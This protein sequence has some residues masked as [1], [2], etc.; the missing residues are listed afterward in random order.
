MTQNGRLSEVAKRVSDVF[1]AMGETL[2]SMPFPGLP[3]MALSP[4]SGFT[5]IT[6]LM[7]ALRT[8]FDFTSSTVKGFFSTFTP[9]VKG[10]ATAYTGILYGSVRV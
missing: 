7:A 1:I 3:L 8:A 9:I 4:V 5:T 6:E 10:F 2:L